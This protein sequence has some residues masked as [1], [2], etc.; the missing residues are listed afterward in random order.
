MS[1]KRAARALLVNERPRIL[2]W[3]GSD[4]EIDYLRRKWTPGTDREVG[5]VE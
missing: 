5:R 4:E 3:K 1:S 2:I